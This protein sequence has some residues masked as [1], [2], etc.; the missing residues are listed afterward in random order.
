LKATAS[1]VQSIASL[2]G[3]S[4]DVRVLRDRSASEAAL[5][6]RLAGSRYV[7]LATHGF[8]ADPKIRSAF[9]VQPDQLRLGEFEMTGRRST[10]TG[11]NPLILSGVV[12][13][14]AN[15]PQ[16]TNEWGAPVGDDGIL[17]A[18]EV[19]GL[20]L[21]G[22]ELVVLSACET[23]LGDVAGGEGVFGLQRAFGLAGAR[24]VI[25]SLWKVDDAAT[26]ALMVEFYRNLWEKKLGKLEALRQAQ[27][28]MIRGY[29]PQQGRL[30]GA[31]PASTVASAATRVA[32]AALCPRS[33][34][35]AKQDQ[36]R[37]G[38]Q[39]RRVEPEAFKKAQ[40]RLRSGDRLLPPFY[41][42]SFVLS[43][44]WR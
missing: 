39:T 43:G 11:R 3:S 22:T 31:A 21:A 23:G 36:L 33:A 41:W 30:R 28:A 10:V 6:E 7:H 38:G 5:R 15:V 32:S 1:E 18:E 27:L 19:V 13:A 9:Q 12:L 29:D 4:E 17:T 35:Q 26:E 37:G 14:G 16:Q 8:F 20:D 40:E 24:S 2:R 42:S 44:D 25:A 34:A